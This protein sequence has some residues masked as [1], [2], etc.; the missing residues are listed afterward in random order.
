M[1]TV[2]LRGF[3]QTSRQ[4][5]FHTDRRSGKINEM[6]ADPRAALH[7]YDPQQKVQMQIDGRVHL[8]MDDPLA[9]QAWQQTQA[10]S[11]ITYQ[12]TRAPGTVIDSPLD[13]TQDAT[14]NGGGSENFLVATLRIEA[15]EWLFLDARGHRRAR[16]TREGDAWRGTWLVP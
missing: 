8:H 5:W 3:D 16:F 4:V 1:R 12:V 10:M 7:V 9:Q 2:V 11:R 13:A 14:I 6:R 15:L